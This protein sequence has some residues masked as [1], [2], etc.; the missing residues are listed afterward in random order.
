MI[1]LTSHIAMILVVTLGP[2]SLRMGSEMVPGLVA[3]VDVHWICMICTPYTQTRQS[4]ISIREG[5]WWMARMD[6]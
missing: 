1:G 4:I 3:R 2:S 6:G 5:K